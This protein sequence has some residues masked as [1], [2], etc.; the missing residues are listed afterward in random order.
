MVGFEGMTFRK[1]RIDKKVLFIY[2]YCTSLYCFGFGEALAE[3]APD[4]IVV[5]DDSG[6]EVVLDL[7]KEFC[8]DGETEGVLYYNKK[9]DAIGK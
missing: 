5:K 8:L 2:N 9:V 1:E 4:V 6:N 7:K 3:P